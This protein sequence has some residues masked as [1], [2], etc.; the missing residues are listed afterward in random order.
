MRVVLAAL[1]LAIAGDCTGDDAGCRCNPLACAGEVCGQ[2][3]RLAGDARLHRIEPEHGWTT[4]CG[5]EIDAAAIRVG[6]D[7]A[8]A[9]LNAGGGHAPCWRS[10]D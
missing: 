7:E 5:L 9:E 2:A 8:E 6:A 10:E 3:I 4:A 1:V